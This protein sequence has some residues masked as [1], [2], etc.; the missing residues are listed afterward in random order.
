M[1]KLFKLL[2]IIAITA[3]IGFSIIT[4]DDSGKFNDDYDYTT[5]PQTPPASNGPSTPEPFSNISATKLVA[6]IKV[7]WNLGNTLDAVKFGSNLPVPELE[8]AWENPVTTK[9]MIT[10]IKDAGFNA[11][12][13]PVSWTKCTDSDYNIREDWMERVTEIVNYAV[14]NDMYILLNTHHDGY[15]FKLI[16]NI[17]ASINAF[18]KIWEQIACNFQNYNEK[19]I[20]EALN[21]PRTSGSSA[22]WNGGTSAEHA[23]LNEYYKVFVKIVRSCGGNNDKRFLMIN[24]Y[25]A[26]GL[27]EAMKGL[28]IPADTAQNKIIV[29]YHAYEPYDFALNEKSSVKTWNKSSGSDTSPITSRINLAYNLFVSNGIPVVIGEFGALDKDNES[30]RAA[31]AEFYVKSAAEKGIKCFW[32][33]NG[34]DFKIFDRNNNTFTYPKIKNGL[35]RGAGVIQ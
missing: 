20:F 25:A 14:D 9:E 35:L 28:K 11:I 34:G 3:I 23:N 13:I 12:R 7:G 18:R 29:S 6:D 31:W 19:L 2:G 16:G 27:S 4:C 24:S 10:A 1:K 17:T 30:A 26:S 8:T 32:W 5:I 33:D 22:E 15:A 21:E